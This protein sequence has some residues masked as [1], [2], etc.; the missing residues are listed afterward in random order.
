MNIRRA[1][2]EDV[3]AIAGVLAAAFAEYRPLYTP[4]AFAATTISEDKIAPRLSE[5]PIWVVV[6]GEAVVGTL[7]TLLKN[8]GLY[9]R[10]MG[11]CPTA[12]G[13]GA[14]ILLLNEAE[15]FARDNGATYLYLSTTPFLTRAIRLYER[16]GFRRSKDG[17]P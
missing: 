16:W 1:V 8:G 4:E 15:R 14:G 5:G 7:S 2:A 12:R 6:E 17:P 3:A 9:L 10:S 13:Q 11:I